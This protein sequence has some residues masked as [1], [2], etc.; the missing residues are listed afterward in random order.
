[1]IEPTHAEDQAGDHQF[2]IKPERRGDRP[3]AEFR[4]IFELTSKRGIYLMTDECYCHFL[5]DEQA[6]LDC[7]RCQA[8]KRRCWWPDRCRK[9]MP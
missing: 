8:R 2:A 4:K 5:Y 6:V 1:M 9:L 3:Q 7:S